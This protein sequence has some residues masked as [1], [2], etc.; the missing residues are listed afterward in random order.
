M[1][2]DHTRPYGI[3]LDVGSGLCL[4]AGS[5]HAVDD[6][7]ARYGCLAWFD[8]CLTLGLP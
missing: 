6:C 2:A 8:R 5:G 1:I 4:Y 3:C 7:H